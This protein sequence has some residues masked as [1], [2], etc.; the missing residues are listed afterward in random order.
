MYEEKK[1]IL[2]VQVLPFMELKDHKN[3]ERAFIWTTPADFSE[4]EPSEELFA[5]MFKSNEDTKLWKDSWDKAREETKKLVKTE[6]KE[7]ETTEKKEGEATEK[8]ESETTEKKESETTEK[9]E[10]EKKSD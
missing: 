5:I 1:L 6:K 3:R 10:E 4:E 9:K 7:G 2:N 8:K